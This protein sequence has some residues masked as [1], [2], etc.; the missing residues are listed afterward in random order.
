MK[1]NKYCTGCN[2]KSF[3]N[4]A[5]YSKCPLLKS[6]KMSKKYCIPDSLSITEWPF[7]EVEVPNCYKGFMVFDEIPVCPK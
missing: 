2:N 1:S 7:V 6:A 5:M 3:Y 4:K